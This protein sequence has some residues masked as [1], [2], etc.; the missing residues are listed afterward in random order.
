MMLGVVVIMVASEPVL[1]LLINQLIHFA[2]FPTRIRM[3]PQCLDDATH[4]RCLEFASTVPHARIRC[5]RA[6]CCKASATTTVLEQILLYKWVAARL[7]LLQGLTTILVDADALVKTEACLHEWLAY[8]EPFVSQIG[9]A[10]M[11]E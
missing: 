3:E 9:G 5:V 11:S 7:Y 8:T 1:R 4:I 6:P 2:A 10:R